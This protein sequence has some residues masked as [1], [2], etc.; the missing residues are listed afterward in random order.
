MRRL[1]HLGDASST[2][3]VSLAGERAV[4]RRL[5]HLGDASTTIGIGLVVLAAGQTR[6]GAAMLLAN[7]L[8]HVPVQLLKRVVAR[9]RPSDAFGQ[10]LALVPLPDQF[11]FPSGHAAAATAVAMTAAIAHPW[12]ASLALPLAALVSYSRVALR[13][14]HASDVLA[15]VILGLGGALAAA[16]LL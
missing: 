5:T 3:G 6:L 8:S 15:G 14:H 7:V 12:T 10:P 13:V 1:T 11:S 2:I 9:P 4:M 16:A